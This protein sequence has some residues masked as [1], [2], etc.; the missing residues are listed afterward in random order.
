[1]EGATFLNHL[2]C[3]YI[4]MFTVNIYFTMFVE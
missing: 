2:L 1:M 4:K 3:V